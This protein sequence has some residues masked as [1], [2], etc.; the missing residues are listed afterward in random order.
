MRLYLLM[1][2]S[3][4]SAMTVKPGLGMLVELTNGFIEECGNLENRMGSR[5]R[6]VQGFAPYSTVLY[7]YIYIVMYLLYKY[8]SDTAIMSSCLH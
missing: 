2:N 1:S 5:M 3:I 6:F 7:I 4:L 8:S